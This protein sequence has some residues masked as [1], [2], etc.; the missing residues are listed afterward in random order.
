MV[1]DVKEPL[2]LALEAAING[3]VD[4]AEDLLRARP[5]DDPRVLFN[6]GW[7]DLRH[8]N[9]QKGMRGL[10]A[11]RFIDVYGSKP[12]TTKPIW[13]PSVH[14]PNG[15][16]I[17]LR[18]EGGYGDEIINA[19]FAMDI[20]KL[21]A[22]A[23]VAC[24]PELMSLVSRI[25]GVSA[26]VS[27]AAIYDV[28]YDYWIPGQSAPHVVGH[29]F[30]TLSG[31]PY[32][33]PRED[34]VKKWSKTIRGKL[35]V[36]IRWQGSPKFE[37]QQH[38]LFDPEPL[39]ELAKIDGVSLYSLQR[40]EGADRLPADSDIV[41]LSPFLT[42]WEDTAG[43]I[44]NLDLVITSCTSVAHLAAAMGKPTW[45]IVPV[46]PYYVWAYPWGGNTSPWYDSVRVF[47]QEK[48]GDWDAPLMKVRKVL[49]A[50][51]GANRGARR[52][53]NDGGMT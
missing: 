32:I 41:D 42:T 10:D 35:K 3:H 15:K 51:V 44:A 19:R 29:T 23:V 20:A 47:R 12:I 38:R 14:N 8:G 16:Y 24:H 11:G 1:A 31:K 39:F 9:L 7:H 21:G 18:S 2:D 25:E 49:Q 48:Y 22:K 27:T 37:H 34:L 36:G 43:I 28:H 33:A 40:D 17:L 50:L 6:I 45:V 5:Q 52:D 53:V 13:N 4:V 46:L 30:E 26:A